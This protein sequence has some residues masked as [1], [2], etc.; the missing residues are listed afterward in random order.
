MPRVSSVWRSFWALATI[1]LLSHSSVAQ[2]SSKLVA[3]K[4][5]E[6]Y[7]FVKRYTATAFAGEIQGWRDRSLQDA[8][9]GSKVS[10]VP[11]TE[12]SAILGG[13]EAKR[14]YD[15]TT[16]KLA[17]LAYDVMFLEDTLRTIGYK[18]AVILPLVTNYE[19]AALAHIKTYKGPGAPNSYKQQLVDKINGYQ[20]TILNEHLSE[21]TN[22]QMECGGAYAAQVQLLTTPIA[23]R[24]QY[25]NQLFYNICEFQHLDPTK[26]DCDHWTDYGGHVAL[27]AGRYKIRVVWADG[28]IVYRDLNVDDVADRTQRDGET[29]Y[30]FNITK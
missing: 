27:L 1:V 26:S 16:V 25:I 21:V 5:H 2:T 3:A 14:Y 30:P 7:E 23:R 18:D 13:P 15:E 29:I 4:P 6:S 22:E 17:T 19:T 12:A 8:K 24:V 10:L 9:E 28:T 11:C 20:H